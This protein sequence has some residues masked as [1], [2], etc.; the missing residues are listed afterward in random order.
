M[1]P[2]EALTRLLEDVRGHIRAGRGRDALHAAEEAVSQFPSE[3][4]SHEIRANVLFLVER[5]EDSIAAFEAALACNPRRGASLVNLGAV[6]NRIQQYDKAVEVLRKAVL[7]DKRS[8]EAYYNL[9][10]AHRHLKQFAMAVPAYKEAI[11]LNPKMADAHQNLGNVYLEMQNYHQAINSYTK[12]LEIAP[13]HDRARRG[14]QRAH[15]A[16]DASKAEASPFG[17]LVDEKTLSNQVGNAPKLRALSAEERYQDRHALS[18]FSGS[19]ERETRALHELIEAQIRP[20]LK[21]L[22]R[23]FSEMAGAATLKSQRKELDAARARLAIMTRKL[24]D[25]NTAVQRHESLH[26]ETT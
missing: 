11:R 6:Y 18:E 26:I 22:N 13:D 3:A 24:M 21:Q 20:I 23:S 10:Y 15:E 12:A 8:A 25:L 7:T 2:P 5:Y 19:M 16:R 1:S 17:R 9:G 4:E 14:L